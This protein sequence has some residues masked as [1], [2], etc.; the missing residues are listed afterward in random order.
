MGQIATPIIVDRE[1]TTIDKLTQA[2]STSG[3]PQ[4]TTIGGVVAG[5]SLGNG[6]VLYRSNTGVNGASQNMPIVVPKAHRLVRVEFVQATSSGTND[7]TGISITLKR[8]D[9]YAAAA[10]Q[11]SLL[12]TNGT[13][14]VDSVVFVGA[15]GWE[16]DA[17]IYII[18]FT[19]QNTD[20]LYVRFYVQ[21]L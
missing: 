3:V 14:A 5:I 1:A 10:N 9:P 11:I 16:A 15:T 4:V 13:Q 8:Q 21:Y 17:S 12:S 7:A 20:T 18:N 19:G 2:T 6:L